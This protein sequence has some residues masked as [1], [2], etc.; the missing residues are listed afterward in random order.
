M[1][2]RLNELLRERGILKGESKYYV[3]LAHT[4]EDIRFTRDAWASALQELVGR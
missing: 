4:P 1:M 2:R 3:S